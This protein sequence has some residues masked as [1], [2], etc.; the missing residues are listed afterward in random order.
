MTHNVPKG[1]IKFFSKIY[2][3]QLKGLL[4]ISHLYPYM[5]IFITGIGSSTKYFFN[6][7]NVFNRD[8]KIPI[9]QW[10]IIT[11]FSVNL[12]QKILKCSSA[13][14]PYPQ[15]LRKRCIPPIRGRHCDRCLQW[16]T[17]RYKNDKL[18]S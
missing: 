17:V 6:I 9:E 8:G 1:I 3:L 11:A 13:N 15:I 18:E 7:L 12:A 10:R 16:N 4:F 2:L 14:D 5:S